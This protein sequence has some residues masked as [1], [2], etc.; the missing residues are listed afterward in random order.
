MF[1]SPSITT[2]NAMFSRPDGLPLGWFD[3][4]DVSF[5]RRVY[6]DLVPDGGRTAE[7]GVYRGRSI[8]SVADII[9]RKSLHVFCID[10]FQLLLCDRDNTRYQHFLSTAIQYHIRDR[11]TILKQ[12]S[13][14]A[15]NSIANASLDFVFI[16]A[17]HMEPSVTADIDAWLP[18]LRIGGW[19]GG[20]D[21]GHAGVKAAVRKQ[22]FDNLQIQP[23]SS[24]WLTQIRATA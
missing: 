14:V 4:G 12:D 20:H 2:A 10:H 18:K 5:Y 17:D 15:A 7:I 23:G 11:M 6:S 9:R 1:V 16:D 24:I 13:I 21:Y 22:R 8:C 19:L 3:S